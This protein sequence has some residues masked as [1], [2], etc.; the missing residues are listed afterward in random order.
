MP[1]TATAEVPADTTTADLDP[2]EAALRAD[3]GESAETIVAP[4]ASATADKSGEKDAPKAGAKPSDGAKPGEKKPAEAGKAGEDANDTP[5][6]K[7][8]KEAERRDRSWKALEQ[9][10]QEFRAE[11]DRI[12]SDVIA[13]RREVETL[14]KGGA[15]KADAGKADEHGLTADDYDRAAKKYEDEGNT[16]MAALAKKRVEKMRQQPAASAAAGETWQQ[17]EFQKE[18]QRHTD[19]LIAGDAELAKPDNPLV[20]ATQALLHDGTFGRFFRAHPDGIK[21]AFEVAKLMR[22]A[23]SAGE[24]KKNLD[25]E[26]AAHAKS[27][28]EIERLNALLQPHGGG[29]GQPPAGE[30]SIAQMNGEEADAEVRRI[31][32][33]ADRGE[34]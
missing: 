20:K 17:P 33:A 6:K 18:W 34:I 10:K 32:A 14:R 1:P 7:A 15:A 8:Q 25:A 26:Q 2:M 11:R 5:F 4:K 27:K 9:E 19:E 22:D 12:N 30:K 29:R 31:A 24:V 3:A 28:K 23:H 13:L 21:A 16:E